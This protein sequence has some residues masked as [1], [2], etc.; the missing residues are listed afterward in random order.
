MVSVSLV[1]GVLGVGN[2][3]TAAGINYSALMIFCLV[4]GFVG[5]GISLLLSKFMAKTMMGVEIVDDRGQYGEL[6]RKVHAMARQAGISKMPEVGVYHSPEVNAFATGPSKNNALVAV[7]TGLLQQMNTD[8]VEGVLAHEVAHVANGD[9]VT[10]A[11]VQGVVNAFV[12]FFA[13]IAAFA[14]QNFLSGDRDDDRPANTGWAYH[15]SVMVF[16]IVF[17]FLGMFVVAYFSRIREFRADKGG[18][19]YAGKYK[20][21]AAL[22]RLQQKLDFVDDSQDAVKTMKISSKKGLMNFLSTHPSLEDRIAA[23]ERSY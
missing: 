18:A 22:K 21:I 1:L 9:M 23:L 8:E 6:V 14:L 15:L 20:M 5:S 2:Y 13:R 3:L 12:M 19:Q 4:W 10:M 16:E 7:S 17:S 11:L